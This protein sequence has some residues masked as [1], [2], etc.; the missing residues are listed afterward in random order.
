M[1]IPQLCTMEPGLEEPT[2]TGE[3]NEP[4][5]ARASAKRG[6]KRALRTL[7]EPARLRRCVACFEVSLHLVASA[8]L[9]AE[10]CLVFPALREHLVA[11]KDL[12][13]KA[14]GAASERDGAAPRFWGGRG[15]ART[16]QL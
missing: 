13:R 16:V 14:A 8:M 11:E 6:A 12:A 15:S 1:C 5:V 7:L 3:P 2:A 4:T 10:C 9:Q